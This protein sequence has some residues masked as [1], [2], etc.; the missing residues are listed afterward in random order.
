MIIA[1]NNVMDVVGLA[2]TSTAQAFSTSTKSIPAYL[3]RLSAKAAFLASAQI[4]SSRG[5]L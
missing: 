3:R 2:F 4:S 5:V 1:D